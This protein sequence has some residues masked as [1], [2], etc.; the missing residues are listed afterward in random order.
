MD[1]SL[2]ILVG[3]ACIAVGAASDSAAAGNLNPSAKKV[4]R[5]EKDYF[6]VVNGEAASPM[7]EIGMK[8]FAIQFADCEEFGV[9]SS[10]QVRNILDSQVG[11]YF[12]KYKADTGIW[13]A[14]N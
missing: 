6:F 7:P 11:P 10:R 9:F 4:E 1:G 3:V 13:R 5:C 8:Y 2:K 12:T 14:A